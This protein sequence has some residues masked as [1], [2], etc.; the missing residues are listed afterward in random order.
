MI[1]TKRDLSLNTATTLTTI[2]KVLFFS[3]HSSQSWSDV[4]MIIHMGMCVH[5]HM[6]NFV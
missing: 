5:A 1:Q 3:T 6:Y 2:F 4:A